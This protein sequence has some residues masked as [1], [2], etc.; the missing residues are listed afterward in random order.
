M[1]DANYLYVS[2][3]G[4][5]NS[6]LRFDAATGAPAPA[7]GQTGAVFVAPGVGEQEVDGP[8]GM[9]IGPDGNLYVSNN[10]RDDV[11]RYDIS[12]G[13]RID[14]FV[15]VGSGGLDQPAGLFFDDAG[16]LC[17]AS[18]GTH[19]ILRY[20]GPNGSSPGD[21]L[22]VLIPSQSGGLDFPS[23]MVVGPE[24]DLYVNSRD[25][26][27]VLRYD[28]ES[29]AFLESIAVAR[30]GSLLAPKGITFD[31]NGVLYVTSSAGEQVLR[32][33][34]KSY[35]VV[36]VD[37]SMP[38]PETV[39]VDFTT[40]DGTA[41]AGADYSAASGIV[42]FAPGETSKVIL[43]PTVDDIITESEEYFSVNLS[44]PTGG[45][46]IN[47]PQGIATILD[48]DGP[49]FSD[50]FEH[51]QWNG[52][53]VE[54]SQNDW[55]TST[56]RKTDGSYSAE[57][58]GAASDAKLSL[59]SPID[60]TPYG[61][62][63][64]SFDWLIESGLDTGEY[65]ALDLFNGAAWQEVARLRGNVDAEN[66]WH[67]EVL[68]VDGGY[69]V[70]NFQFR[71]RA[72]MS[73]SDE[74][75]NLDNVQ[76]V[77]TSLAAPNVPPVADIG[78]PYSGSE[79]TAITLDASASHDPDGAIASY[80]WDLDNDGQYDDASGVT[81]TFTRTADGTYT[82][83]LRVTDNRGD[84]DTASTSVTVANV[85]PTADAGGPYTTG[86]G[87]DVTLS[88]A[89]S[90]DPG[91]DI[92][93]YAWDLDGDGQYDDATGVTAT[94][95][96]PTEGTFTVA[97]KVTD[98]DG[99]SATHEALVNVV[100]SVETVVFSDSFEAGQWN[101]KWVE[102]S[103][104]DWFTSTQRAT[105]GNYSAEVDGRATN[106]TLSMSNAVDLTAYGSA[107][108]TFDWYI[109]SSFDAGE[110]LALDFSPNGSTWTEIRRLRGN[111]DTENTWHTETIQVGSAYLTD[112]FKIRFRAYVSGSD[113]DA[114][115]DNVQLV[116]GGM[117]SSSASTMAAGL[118][119]S[120][121]LWQLLAADQTA[122]EHD[123]SRTGKKTGE[124]TDLALLEWQLAE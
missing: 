105:A 76:L 47:D 20:Q 71:F 60:L 100:S 1:F 21:Y 104:N 40:A 8:Y 4:G 91:N 48:T 87:V 62:A 83:G 66:T 116:A 19:E 123:E 85:A 112:G 106:A 14:V 110:Y 88:A 13:A 12:T 41:L 96:S 2:N 115:V 35:A 99:A 101:G 51:G 23:S 57:V 94:F 16:R 95:N 38:V 75:A 56:Q 37:L 78:G 28:M 53:W 50:S 46:V 15:A 34:P 98:D 72:K 29:G 42:T 3:A 97:V 86:E 77:A 70:S 84:T 103:Q 111:V 82:I 121:E 10:R 39:T 89:G 102:D 107:E 67:H 31:A 117:S 109:E 92:A 69:L 119:A 79:G 55:F 61:S 68:T 6:V 18:S 52:L 114:N 124:L 44:N 58:D 65:L 63:E 120:E 25:S 27:Q 30:P 5:M 24:G 32:S 73:G 113:E 122:R 45:A 80:D 22:D 93:S 17:V 74:D 7:P 81:T 64:L 59:A 43:V 11:T 118:D 26:N 54:D 33:A 36:H 49:L 108:L 9:T 90:T